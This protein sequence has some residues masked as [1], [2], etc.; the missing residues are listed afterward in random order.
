MIV[1]LFRIFVLFVVPLLSLA[2][3]SVDFKTDVAP[4]LQGHPEFQAE[5][6][7]IRFDQLGAGERVSGRVAPALGGQRVG[8]YDFVAAT[9]S[10]SVRVHFETAVRF[11]DAEGRRLA[12]VR[13]GQWDGTEDL[14]N[15]VRIEEEVTLISVKPVS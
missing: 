4:L 15:A 12:E 10:S 13:D 2:G 7:G 6:K 14:R 9:K 3:G 5:L 1:P 8:P 11:F